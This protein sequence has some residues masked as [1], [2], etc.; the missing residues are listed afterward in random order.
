MKLGRRARRL[1]PATRG[2]EGLCDVRASYRLHATGRSIH[3]VESRSD[4]RHFRDLAHVAGSQILP[5]RGVPDL[6]ILQVAADVPPTRHLASSASQKHRVG[7][8]RF[9]HTR[10][11]AVAPCSIIVS[12]SRLSRLHALL[13]RRSG[14]LIK[15]AQALIISINV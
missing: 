7:Q 12:T 8:T 14:N 13:N 3:H 15:T 9:A 4:P 6:R 5:N 2:I 11:S 10:K 1:C